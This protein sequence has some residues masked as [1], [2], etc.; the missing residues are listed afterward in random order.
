MSGV[1]CRR[2]KSHCDRLLW[3]P[4]L[5]R[6]T[7]LLLRL[8]QLNRSREWW[9]CSDG[10]SI[11]VWSQK[12]RCKAHRDVKASS[13]VFVCWSS[14][15]LTSS[16][17]QLS[18]CVWSTIKVN[19]TKNSTWPWEF[20][21]HFD[22]PSI[23]CECLLPTSLYLCWI[24]LLL[25]GHMSCHVPSVALELALIKLR[26]SVSDDKFVV[27]IV[28]RQKIFCWTP[29][30]TSKSL[31]LASATTSS[32]EA[33]STRSVVVHRMPLQNC[34][35][36]SDV[37]SWNVAVSHL[38]YSC[39]LQSTLLCMCIRKYGR[40]TAVLFLFFSALFV[41]I[42][43]LLTT[44]PCLSPRQFATNV[45]FEFAVCNASPPR[46]WTASRLTPGC[47]SSN[48]YCKTHLRCSGV[49]GPLLGKRPC[50]TGRFPVPHQAIWLLFGRHCNNQ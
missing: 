24:Y 5:T 23:Q 19:S 44:L 43:G 46:P 45:M 20:F 42:S 34:S 40:L 39:F 3:F 32:L 21:Q 48:R 15:S 1:A 14:S 12:V 28:D 29:T 31:T 35:K 36:V 6:A 26:C 2:R 50:A 25:Y 27:V 22:K 33:S 49:V 47:V 30:W 9:L 38:V 16:V 37:Y 7:W 11:C 17:C 41:F 10:S 13:C 8:G 4:W 18:V